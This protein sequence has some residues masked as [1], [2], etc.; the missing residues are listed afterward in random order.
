MA[1]RGGADLV[2]GHHPHVLQGIDDKLAAFEALRARLGIPP[3]LMPRYARAIAILLRPDDTPAPGQAS[4]RRRPPDAP[5]R[6]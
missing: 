3:P 4:A 1:L 5:P 2:I 6:C